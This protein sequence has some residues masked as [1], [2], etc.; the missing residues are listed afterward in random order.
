MLTLYVGLG[1]RA[2]VVTDTWNVPSFKNINGD[3]P[4]D[5]RNFLLRLENS[6]FFGADNDPVAIP[7]LAV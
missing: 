1:R 2:T 3:G 4:W 6:N 5:S 7:A